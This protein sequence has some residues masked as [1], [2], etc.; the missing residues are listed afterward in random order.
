MSEASGILFIYFLALHVRS[1]HIHIFQGKNLETAF[2]DT[3]HNR[4]GGLL[5]MCMVNHPDNES[6]E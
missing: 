2:E 6:Q 5:D 1:T 4:F 3:M